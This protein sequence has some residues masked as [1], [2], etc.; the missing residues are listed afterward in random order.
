MY[1]SINTLLVSFTSLGFKAS[2]NISRIIVQSTT[3]DWQP[4][5]N[6]RNTRIKDE[7][8][9]EVLTFKEI[10]WGTMRIDADAAYKPGVIF[11]FIL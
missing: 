2:V 9:G 8:K 5:G 3:P 6:L 11:I 1:V 4:T 7:V 10:V